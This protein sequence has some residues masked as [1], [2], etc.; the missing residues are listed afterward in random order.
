MPRSRG[1][2]RPT[3]RFPTSPLQENATDNVTEGA[4]GV[5]DS[6]KNG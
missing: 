1:P 2:N 3:R 5:R 6:L 4:K